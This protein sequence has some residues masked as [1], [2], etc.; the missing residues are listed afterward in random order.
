MY[1]TYPMSIQILSAFLTV[2][3]QYLI[4]SGQRTAS[5][6]PYIK[7]LLAWWSIQYSL[8]D[9]MGLAVYSINSG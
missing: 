8:G 4:K 2:N 9:A 3:I 1:I 6:K 7:I 5:Y